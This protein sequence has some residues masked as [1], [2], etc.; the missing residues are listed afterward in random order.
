MGWVPDNFFLAMSEMDMTPAIISTILFAVTMLL[1]GEDCLPR[2]YLLVREGTEILLRL[3]Y[4]IIRV[5]PY[6]V[7]ALLAVLM[8]ATGTAPYLRIP[9]MQPQPG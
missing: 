3:T 6:G 1:I 9:A 7:F 5:S 2:A 4:M 8:G